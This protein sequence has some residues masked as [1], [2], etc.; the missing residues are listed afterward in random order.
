VSNHITILFALMSI[1]LGGVLL[2]QGIL[3]IDSIST[4]AVSPFVMI[5]FGVFLTMAGLLGAYV[6]SSAQLT[7][8][9]YLSNT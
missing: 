7:V 6:S 5:L 1:I 8:I 3:L 2:G 9:C 4:V